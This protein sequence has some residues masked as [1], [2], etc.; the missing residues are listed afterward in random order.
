LVH[1]DAQTER[2]A[3]KGKMTVVIA[4]LGILL[5]GIGYASLIYMSY[6]NPLIALGLMAVGLISAT[7]GTYLI[8]G[9][10]LPVMINK[11]KSNKKHSEKGLNAF[12]FAQLNFRINGLTN[13][14]ATVAILVALGAGGIACGMA[15]KNNII[16][17]TDQ[18]RIYDSVIHNPT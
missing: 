9:S 5:L 7:V 11:L 2:V 12:T 10:L 13:V 8:F 17:M 4:F 16:N 18:M 14:L 3:I 6:A 1:A 15:F